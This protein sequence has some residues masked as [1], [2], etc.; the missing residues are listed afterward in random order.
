MARILSK[1]Q[2]LV[3]GEIWQPPIKMGMKLNTGEDH[4]KSRNE[5]ATINVGCKSVRANRVPGVF[6]RRIGDV[7]VNP[8]EKK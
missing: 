3:E 6:A 1:A 5:V 8:V 2:G 7:R 4:M